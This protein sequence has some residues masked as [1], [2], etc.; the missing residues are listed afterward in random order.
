VNRSTCGSALRNPADSQDGA[1]HNR[2]VRHAQKH[3][4]GKDFFAQP[5]RELGSICVQLARRA[6]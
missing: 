4:S 6:I 5:A 2:P 3:F 1:I